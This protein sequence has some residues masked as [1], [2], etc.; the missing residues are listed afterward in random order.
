MMSDEAVIV[1]AGPAGLAAAVVLGQHGVDVRVVD[2]Q[3]RAGGQIYRRPPAAFRVGGA[4]AGEALLDAAAAAPTVR[5]ERSTVAWGI[6]GGEADDDG[7]VV[8][9]A[10]RAAV[11]PVSARRVLLTAGAYDLPF[12]FPGWTLPGVMAVGGVQAFLKAQKLLAGRR[13]VLAGAHP[14]LLIVAGQLVAAGADVAVVALA[15]PRPRIL[16]SV[17]SLGLGNEAL[18]RTAEMARALR[19]LRSHR[20]PIR[21]GTMIAQAEGDDGVERAWL[22]PVDASWRSAG[23]ERTA[24]DCDVVALGYGFVPSTELAR[25]AGCRHGWDPLG[26]WVV[27]H[28]EWM[29]SSRDPIYV[30]GEVTGIAGAP[31]AIEEGRLAAIGM[32]RDLDRIDAAGAERL[33]ARTRRRLRRLRN[34]SSAMRRQFGPRFEALANC[35]SD[36]TVVCRCEEITAGALR[37]ALVTHAHVAELDAVKLLTRVGM[38]PCQGRMCS[39]T[40]AAIVSDVRGCG[41]RQAGP[42]SARAPI[43]PLRLGLLADAAPLTPAARSDTPAEG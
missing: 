2:E 40:T 32:L 13:F 16:D 23:G 4:P 30:A 17:R 35:A 21:F 9:L 34:Q 28:D 6:F 5:W 31:Q 24:I 10:D 3:E 15:H 20:V 37:S 41:M 36:E 18:S 7:V 11:Q 29:R 42:F 38:G 33:A 27:A 14:L 8:G 26:G 25:Q 12:A 22:K 19:R 39:L 1:G 43:K